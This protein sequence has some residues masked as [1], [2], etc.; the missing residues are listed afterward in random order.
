M[1]KTAVFTLV[2][3]MLVSL[4]APAALAADDIG[5]VIA[6]DEV[7]WTDSTPF[8]DENS[9]TLVPLRAVA[10]AAGL[11]VVWDSEAREAIFSKTYTVEDAIGYVE[12]DE[13][14]VSLIEVHFPID[15]KIAYCVYED[16]VIETEEA[17]EGRY[18]IEM[19][20]A[21]VIVEDRTFAPIR[22]LVEEFGYLVDWNAETRTVEV[23]V[24]KG[25]ILNWDYFAKDENGAGIFYFPAERFDEF[26]SI[27][28]T[29]AKVN[30]VEAEVVTLTADEMAALGEE[31]AKA[32]FAFR[33]V[34]EDVDF[35]AS[36]APIELEWT[37]KITVVD[38]STFSEVTTTTIEAETV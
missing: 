23:S 32:V 8:I 21:A 24:N 9:R 34:A 5:V 28:V 22:Y 35:A 6:G 15:S 11:E 17:T 2:I 33:I 27:E 31:Y 13:S 14:Y 19:D 3:M 7:V 20:T 29:A 38:E 10:E 30:G 26:S 16:F 25:S 1:K 12:G 4:A 36:E 18:D 37:F